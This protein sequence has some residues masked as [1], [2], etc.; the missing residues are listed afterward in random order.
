MK[1]I[2]EMCERDVKVVAYGVLYTLSVLTLYYV[3]CI[4]S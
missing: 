1:E 2:I 4:F 3:M